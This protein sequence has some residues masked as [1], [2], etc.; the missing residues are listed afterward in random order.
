MGLIQLWKEASPISA[1]SKPLTIFHWALRLFSDLSFPTG[2]VLSVFIV[3]R[4]PL[5]D[6]TALPSGIQL[7]T[8]ASDRNPLNP[9]QNHNT[10]RFKFGKLVNKGCWPATNFDQLHR[11]WVKGAAKNEPARP[12]FVTSQ[13]NA[14]LTPA[15]NLK[16]HYQDTEDLIAT[17]H[18]PFENKFC[19]LVLV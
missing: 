9:P 3:P 16:V 8:A 5:K 12:L 11:Q 2:A 13:R 7:I 10:H 17:E 6:P 14:D 18:P 19:I 15:R 1:L 4:S